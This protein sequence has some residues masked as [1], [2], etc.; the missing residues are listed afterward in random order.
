MTRRSAKRMQSMAKMTTIRVS[1]SSIFAR[2]ALLRLA[3]I[4]TIPEPSPL[5]NVTSFISSKILQHT[6]Y[7]LYFFTNS[8]WHVSCKLTMMDLLCIL[9]IS[10]ATFTFAFFQLAHSRNILQVNPNSTRREVSSSSVEGRVRTG[11]P[12]KIFSCTGATSRLSAAALNLTI[13]P[14]CRPLRTSQPLH[15]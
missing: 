3:S 15:F 2:K 4:I 6:F 1:S 10:S 8:S 14:H 7:P 13:R 9:I 12:L 5:V 11:A